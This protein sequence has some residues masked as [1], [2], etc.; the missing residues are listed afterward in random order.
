MWRRKWG[1]RGKDNK[2]PPTFFSA[3]PQKNDEYRLIECSKHLGTKKAGSRGAFLF[4]LENIFFKYESKKKPLL[5]T[6]API[7]MKNISKRSQ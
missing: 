2:H 5:I 4:K 3:A 6:F 7:S 1:G